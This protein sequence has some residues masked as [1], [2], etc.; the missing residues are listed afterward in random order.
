MHT[1]AAVTAEFPQ[2]LVPVCKLLGNKD[3]ELSITIQK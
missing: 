2:H 3:S 1:F